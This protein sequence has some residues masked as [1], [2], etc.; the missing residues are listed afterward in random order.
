MIIDIVLYAHTGQG[1]IETVLTIFNREMKNRGYKLRFFLAKEPKF[2]EWKDTL[3]N[4]IIYGSDCIDYD[5]DNLVEGYARELMKIEKPDIIIATGEMTSIAISKLAIEKL[6]LKNVKLISWTHLSLANLPNLS[7][8]KCCDAHFVLSNSIA[9]ETSDVI[10]SNKNIYVLKNPVFDKNVDK[11]KLND[12]GVLDLI[13]IG[14]LNYNQKRVD[15][16]LKALSLFKHNNWKLRIIGNEEDK[17]Y[18]KELAYILN[19]EE[20]IEWIDWCKNP[21]EFIEQATA[22]ILSSD[23]EGTP[24]V[25]VEALSR[26]LPVISSNYKGVEDIIIHNENGLIFERGNYESLYKLLNDIYLGKCKLP[27]SE[28]CIQSVLDQ[29]IDH[30]IDKFDKVLKHIR[31]NIRV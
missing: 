18:Y 29:R 24:M 13:Y 9:N 23:F 5:F 6:N 21:W 20:N 19:I 25:L 10:G 15:I 2:K 8:L 12:N 27:K 22:L 17:D 30:A 16:I 7:I 28:Q 1:G 26:G 3:D 14:R 31:N 11:I 4:V